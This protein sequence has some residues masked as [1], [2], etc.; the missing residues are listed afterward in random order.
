MRSVVVVLPA[1]IC[2]AMPIF[3]IRS[4]GTNLGI[5]NLGSKEVR[6]QKSKLPLPPLVPFLPSNNLLILNSTEPARE[7][8]DSDSR[9]LTSGSSSLPPIMREGLIGF[10]HAVDVVSLLDRAAPQVG[11]VV[12]LI[13]Q[14]LRHP[15]L[16]TRP[17]VGDDPAHGQ[18]GAPVLRHFNR[19]LVIGATH[20]A[21]L[22]FQQ[23]LGVL[24]GLL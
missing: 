19:H 22:D 23:R 24:Y 10:R 6:S 16:G 7:T 14:F 5:K 15:L 11:A 20:A 1:S 18:R 3:L 12:Q 13:G 2:A 4:S 17:R 9:L 21:G 8:G